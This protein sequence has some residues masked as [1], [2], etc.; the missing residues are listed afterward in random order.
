[1]YH[2]RRDPDVFEGKPVGCW[3]GHERIRGDSE[4]LRPD[5]EQGTANGHEVRVLARIPSL[6]DAHDASE[7]AGTRLLE[8]PP[9]SLPSDGGPDEWVERLWYRLGHA[10][11]IGGGRVSVRRG[12]PGIGAR[13]GSLPGRLPRS[14]TSRRVSRL[15]WS[16]RAAKASARSVTVAEE[17]IV[18][19]RYPNRDGPMARYCGPNHRSTRSRTLSWPPSTP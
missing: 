5:G 9:A 17:G 7:K 1:M 4:L 11:E 14:R 2:E 13:T 15:R 10:W 8:K 18:D 12:G 16:S 3:F 6:R 19:P